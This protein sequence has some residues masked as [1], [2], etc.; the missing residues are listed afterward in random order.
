MSIE[1][2]TGILGRPKGSRGR[3]DGTV[4]YYWF[5]PNASIKIGLGAWAA[6]T[7]RVFRIWVQNNDRYL[8][9][10]GLRVGRTETEIRRALGAPSSVENDSEQHDKILWYEFLGVAFFINQERAQAFYNAVYAIGVFEQR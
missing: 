3:P 7:G 4:A 9:K 5:D 10:E 6:K 1:E 2:V 8:T